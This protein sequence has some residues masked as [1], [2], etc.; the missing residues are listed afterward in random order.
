MKTTMK[1]E[2]T[3]ELRSL[4]KGT[5]FLMEHSDSLHVCVERTSLSYVCLDLATGYV[6]ALL[7]SIL[8]ESKGKFAGCEEVRDPVMPAQTPSVKTTFGELKEGDIFATGGGALFEEGELFQVEC[9]S[10]KGNRGSAIHLNTEDE[11]MFNHYEE[12]TRA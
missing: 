11:V 5:M 2:G 3:C 6:L 9:T 8:V 10:S 4:D 1:R 12:V 7:G